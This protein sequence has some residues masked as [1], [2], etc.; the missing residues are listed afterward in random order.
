MPQTNHTQKNNKNYKKTEIT[1]IGFWPSSQASGGED[2]TNTNN[3]KNV[4]F[5]MELKTQ[6]QGFRARDPSQK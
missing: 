4:F 2:S 5:E 6:N 1:K 3:T